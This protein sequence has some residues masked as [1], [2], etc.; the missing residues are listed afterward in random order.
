MIRSVS[1]DSHDCLAKTVLLLALLAVLPGLGYAQQNPPGWVA[2]PSTGCRVWNPF[3]LP[4]ET[5]Q[6]E[7]SCVDGFAHGRGTLRWFESGNLMETDSG[8]LR[9]GKL[10]GFAVL[11]FTNGARFEGNF[12]D[13][14]PNGQG[15][16][17]TEDGEVY[18]GQWSYGCFRDGN[19]T[20][21]FGTSQ[22]SCEFH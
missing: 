2:D 15:T 18:S 1:R 22:E 9:R 16:L 17:R 13:H 4:D 20:R 3:P 5:I 8:E 6:W 7:G 12:D 19:R 14:Q 10:N 21:A 11:A